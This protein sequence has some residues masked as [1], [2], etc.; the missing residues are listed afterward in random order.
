[1]NQPVFSAHAPLYFARNISVI[2]LEPYNSTKPSPG[3][4][5][6]PFNW[7][8]WA[9]KPIP[10][11][12]QQDWV[13]NFPDANI[14]IAAGPQSNIIFLD[15]DNAA[16]VI[17]EIFRRLLPSS[18][19]TRVG[20]KGFVVAYR[21]SPHIRSFKIKDEEGLPLI[22][23]LAQGNQAVIP[24]SI[25]PKTQQPYTENCPL[26]SVYDHLPTLPHELENILRA[27]LEEAGIKLS[28]SGYSRMTEWV[29]SGARDN[30]M[31]SMAGM[32]ARDISSGRISL[33]EAWDQMS[34]WGDSLVE[35]VAGD[36]IDIQ[37]GLWKIVEFLERDVTGKRKRPLPLGWD[38]DLSEPLKEH[39][40][41]IF[42]REHEE[43]T[44]TELKEYL[45]RQFSTYTEIHDPK[46]MEAALLVL[47]K[48]A[49]S[50]SLSNL[51]KEM[52]FSYIAQTSRIPGFS[53]PNLRKQ[54]KELQVGP[55]LG[56]N[57]SEIADQ[58]LKTM[59]SENGEVR[60]H[61]GRFWQWDGAQWQS[62]TE[63]DILKRIAEDF[64]DLD[65]SKKHNDHK[66]IVSI[67]KVLA[68]KDLVNQSLDGVNFA[69][70]YLTVH[71]VNNKFELKMLKHNPDLGATST[72][73]YRWL[74]DPEIATNPEVSMPKFM[75]LITDCWG[76]DSDFQEKVAALQ[77]MIGATLFG[78]GPTIQRCAILYGLGDT[79]KS[80]LLSII[81]GLFQSET[82]STVPPDTWQDKY[83][84]AMMVGK[85]INICAEF[86]E[87]K[88]ING[89]SF[90][91][92]VDG[93][94]I[95]AQFK[96]A[97]LFQ[98][99]PKATHW[100]ATNHLPKTAD[101]SSGFTRRLL[102][103]WF[104][105]PVEA[106]NKVLGLH[107]QIL[108]EEREAIAAWAASAVPRLLAQ[109][110]PTIPESH[111]QL[112]MDMSAENNSVRFFLHRCHRV[113]TLKKVRQMA[114]KDVYLQTKKEK[115]QVDLESRFLEKSGSSPTSETI[116]YGEYTSFCQIVAG[117]RPVG[118]R[119]F[120]TRMR[121]ME[122]EHKYQ[123]LTE[124]ESE[125]T[126]YLGVTVNL[127]L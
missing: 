16:P 69:N 91:E 78:L 63:D 22:E 36:A 123:V 77:E 103:L 53:V 47:D 13:R 110:E 50:P 30:K 49:R 102:I 100:F 117:V 58:I 116:L 64:G 112:I 81:K 88:L 94:E 60:F 52:I 2:P 1:M 108:W 104:K 31:T 90:K 12:I 61:S 24:P 3:K 15:V 37:K 126:V 125:D 79:G 4:K 82:V 97:Q 29:P 14:G 38:K 42:T 98:F 105:H 113:L 122:H 20:S 96:H 92:I 87:K 8:Y 55:I 59:Q 80:T 72:L 10:L 23:C 124:G 107:N 74:P 121:E 118:C 62:K 115:S 65:S 51:E 66:G 32:F 89:K 34:T 40:S 45:L 41:K 54:V 5:P 70:G 35:K 68:R 120:R 18:P 106:K 101:S 127:K 28:H 109:K 25:H 48:V 99:S 19:W 73:P 9:D 46:R 44:A 84:P 26:L 11:H 21:W 43:W 75:K 111:E 27:A 39:C 85:L 83:A 114:A 6:I 93:S 56:T 76:Q 71:E 86:D 67:M 57:H 119:T 95:T 33:Q 7:S 17:K